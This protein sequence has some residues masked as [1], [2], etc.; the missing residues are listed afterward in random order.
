MSSHKKTPDE[1]RIDFF[2]HES[3]AAAIRR[4]MKRLGIK[5]YAAYFEREAKNEIIIEANSK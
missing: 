2:L 4:R 1:V 5:T 3:Y